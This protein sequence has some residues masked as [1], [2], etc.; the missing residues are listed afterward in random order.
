MKF[1]DY[2]GLPK[3]GLQLQTMG[4]TDV[5]L[6]NVFN[7]AINPNYIRTFKCR[8]CG[9]IVTKNIQKNAKGYYCDIVCAAKAKGKVLSE[10]V[11]KSAIKIVSNKELKEFLNEYSKY[12]YSEIYKYEQYHEDLIEFWNMKSITIL[13]NLKR[14]KISQKGRIVKYLQKVIKYGYLQILQSRKNEVFYS[15]LSIK[16]QIKILGDVIEERL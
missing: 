8:Y 12:V 15:E 9:N 16:N 5:Y 6:R 2:Y 4:S 11:L 3:I 1:T 10:N 13:A 7:M 14:N